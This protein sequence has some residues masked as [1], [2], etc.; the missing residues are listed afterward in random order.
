MVYR[1]DLLRDNYKEQDKFIK[2]IAEHIDDPRQVVICFSDTA[3]ANGLV[4]WA[5]GRTTRIIGG[6]IVNGDVSIDATTN[7]T[8]IDIDIED[9]SSAK[10][11]DFYAKAET[12]AIDADEMLE[13]VLPASPAFIVE[14]TEIVKVARTITGT[15]G[16]VSVVLDYQFIE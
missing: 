9:G 8:A 11:H 2:Q 15:Q 1:N 10:T 6:R 5:P 13:M 3:A 14:A 7:M 16:E 12:V 4:N